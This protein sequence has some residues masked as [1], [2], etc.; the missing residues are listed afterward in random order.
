MS[1]SSLADG[2]AAIPRPPRFRPNVPKPRTEP[3]GLFAFLKAARENPLTT[4]MKGH[5]EL[6]LI[7][8]E[9]AM[10][11]ITF[12]SDPALI[13]TVLVE[14]AK[15]YR[16]DDLQKRI[17]SPGLGNGLLTAED[18]EWRLQRRTIAPI[19][20][21]RQVDGF[22]EAMNA[23]AARLAKRLTRRNGAVIDVVEE[24]TRVTLDVLERTMFSHGLPR[25]PDALARAITRFL[26]ATGPLDPLDVFGVPSFVPRLGRLRARPAIRFL[27][28]VVDELI[29]R[30]RALMA[31]GEEA[32]TDLLTLL[33]AASD[34]ETGKG[35][36]DLEVRA[37]ISTFIAAGHETTANALTWAVYCLS[38]DHRSRARV[39]REVD[40]AAGADGGFAIGRLPFTKAVMEETM[41]LYPPVPLMTRQAVRDD[42]LGRIKI[43]RGS[44]VVVAPYVLHR[45]RRLW[46]EPDSFV[47]ERFLGADREAIPRFAYLPFGAGPRVCI[48]QSFSVQEATLVLAHVARAVRFDLPADHPPVLPVQRLTLRPQNGLRMRVERR[49]S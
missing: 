21:A 43:P 7:A 32:P 38:Q 6:P 45:H 23:A 14:N 15:N 2:T 19:L 22:Q 26:E 35:L 8:A 28:E 34:P 3:L 16:K 11:R 29:E 9:G 36:S 41:R 46:D 12:V 4:Y 13:R 39:E 48:G 49:R 24:M 37:N 5:F 31:R 20:S 30:R 18:E 1:A 42:R 40:D 10:G 17:L 44:T 47:P 33:L 25:D 27:T